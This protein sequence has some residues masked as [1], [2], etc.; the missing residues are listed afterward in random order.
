MEVYI[1]KVLRTKGLK[2]HLI[3]N[4]FI[5]QHGCEKNEILFFEKFNTSYGP[6]S[7]ESLNFYKSKKGKE[8]YILKLK[9]INSIEEGSLLKGCFI[10]KNFENLPEFIF[11]KKDII[12]CKVIL[13]DKN[14]IIG[15][16]I[17]IIKIKSNYSGL[18]VL[19]KK[20][21]E[22]II[23]P[24]IKEVILKVDTQNKQIFVDSLEG[25]LEEYV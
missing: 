14:L 9:E 17:D 23:I 13:H 15:K 19:T 10:V 3:I 4:F 21:R 6:Y 7:I 20:N 16:V 1:G 12:D 25:V 8:L 22:E 11:L 5:T 18:L 2:G 24:F